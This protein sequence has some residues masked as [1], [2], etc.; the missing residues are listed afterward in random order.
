MGLNAPEALIEV[1][2]VGAIS[3]RNDNLSLSNETERQCERHLS[4]AACLAGLTLL[5]A[6][7]QRGAGMRL[8]LIDMYGGNF[9]G[10]AN[11]IRLGMQIALDEA[12]AAGIVKG[13]KLA[14][15]SADM[16]TSVE[17]AITEA[18]RMILDDKLHY[19]V[20]GSHS[21]AAV[22]LAD[23]VRDKDVFG[24]GAFATTKRFTGEEGHPMIGR[25][26]LS[27]VEIGRI[28]AAI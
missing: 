16:G 15:T 5:A 27:T 18:R 19:V 25:G 3:R 20:V 12:N 1:E 21:G 17:K 22:A 14:L 11:A 23:L 8:G 6:I 9:A 2:A 13:H 24:L 7:S 26:N 28:M 4:E 10:Q